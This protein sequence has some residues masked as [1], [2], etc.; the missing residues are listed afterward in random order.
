VARSRQEEIRAQR[1]SAKARRAAGEADKHDHATEQSGKDEGV[2]ESAM[3]PK[4]A[5]WD[6]EAKS[7]DIKIRNDGA[8][9]A[10]HPHT[11]RHARPVE[12]GSK[13]ESSDRM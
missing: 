6:A 7:N 12:A 5:V 1:E 2:R 3:S 8:H 4:I 9:R 10:G 13:T 11:I